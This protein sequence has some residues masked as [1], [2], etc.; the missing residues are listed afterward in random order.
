MSARKP[1][2]AITM[3]DA[4]GIGPELI[5]QAL[6]NYVPDSVCPLVIGSFEVFK[7]AAK[8]VSSS[9][10]LRKITAPDEGTYRDDVLNIL[11]VEGTHGN[12]PLFGQVSAD[13]G[14]ASVRAIEHAYAVSR[15]FPIKAIVSAPLHKEAMKRAGYDFIDECALM[16]ALTG[17]PAPMMLL[18]SKRLRMATISP[19]HV[20]L[21]KA[22]E[23]VT[24]ERVSKGLDVLFEGLGS[25]GIQ[26]PHVVVAGLNPHAGEGGTLGT[27][28]GTA[29][30]PA[31]D[32]AKRKGFNVSGP[33]PADSLFFKAMRD[34]SVDAVLTMYH[35]QGR[36]AMKTMD[37]GEIVIAMIGV[38]VPFLTVAHGTAHDIAGMG[39]ASPVNM[40]EVLKFAD[41]LKAH[42][43]PA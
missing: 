26:N 36:I 4:A 32:A 24:L 31:V 33:L 42:A 23:N 8:V 18:M 37:F 14:R 1:F 6:D 43:S 38:P 3:G 9:I 17:A 7:R 41:G 40:I 5:L 10:E 12:L 25:F 28:E 11:D 34:A 16:T 22:C 21:K 19:L 20:A 35:D 30:I 27:E 39:K 2:I 13:A 29:I 15:A